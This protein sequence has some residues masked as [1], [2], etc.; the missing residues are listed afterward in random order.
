MVSDERTLDQLTDAFV[1]LGAA[2]DAARVMAAQL[3][4]RARQRAQEQRI[5]EEQALAELLTKVAAGRR[6]DYQGP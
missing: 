4:K 2:R 6:G 3:L 1:H 5:P